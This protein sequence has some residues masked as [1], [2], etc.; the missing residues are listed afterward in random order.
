MSTFYYLVDHKNKVI[1]A[2][3]F[4]RQAWGW[5][6]CD[7]LHLLKF[8]MYVADH[9]GVLGYISEHDDDPE[10]YETINDNDLVRYFPHDSVWD[11]PNAV[12]KAHNA[13]VEAKEK[14]Q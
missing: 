3:C 14:N 6:N 9:D 1:S 7:V 12:E 8:L 2:G 13:W 11:D 5:G 10:G 4:T